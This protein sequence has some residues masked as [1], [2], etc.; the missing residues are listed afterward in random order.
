M[1]QRC[2][3]VRK[4]RSYVCVRE[5]RGL[6]LLGFALYCVQEVGAGSQRL[7]VQITGFG[8][9]SSLSRVIVLLLP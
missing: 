3:R 2:M 6:G 4:E 7:K 9:V 8:R 5:G 1:G